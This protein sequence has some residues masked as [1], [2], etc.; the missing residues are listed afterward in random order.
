MTSGLGDGAGDATA[1]RRASTVTVGVVFLGLAVL[2]ALLA[3]SFWVIATDGEDT[4]DPAQV[5]VDASSCTVSTVGED[6]GVGAAMLS[7]SYSGKGSVDLANA[8]VRYGDERTSATLDVADTTS[9]LSVTLE[10][11]TG[12]YDPSIEND[13]T[14]TLTVPIERIRGEPLRSGERASIEVLID[15]G[16]VASGSVRA[17]N[18]MSESESFVAC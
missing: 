8:T 6:T 18:G 7:V 9:Q 14:L 1:A 3:G 12:A 4:G 16:T 11:G 10:N 5:E 13:E 17:P 2:T 15:S